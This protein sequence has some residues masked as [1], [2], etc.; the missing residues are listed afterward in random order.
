MRKQ[1]GFFFPGKISKQDIKA[2]FS[3]FISDWE[4]VSLFPNKKWEKNFEWGKSSFLEKVID[5]EKDLDFFL[6]HPDLYKNALTII[7]PWENVGTNPEKQTVRASKNIAYLSQKIADLDSILL[8]LWKDITYASKEKIARFVSGSFGYIVEGGAPSV[9]DQKTF[10]HP[11][12]S[13]EDLLSFIEE[14]LLNR[15]DRGAPGIFIC[16]GHQ[17]ACEAHIRLIRR[18]VKNILST[19]KLPHDSCNTALNSLQTLCKKIQ[20]VGKNIQVILQNGSCPAKSWDSSHFATTKNVVPELRGHDLVPYKIPLAKYLNVPVE[21]V[22]I[23]K[24]TAQNKGLIDLMEAYA[25]KIKIDMFHGDIAT[26]QAM[27]FASWAYTSIHYKLVSYR[28]LIAASP[29]RWLMNLPFAV[30][31]LASTHS[32]NQIVTANAATCIFYKDFDSGKF[33]RSFTTQ[34]HPEL[35][36]DLKDFGNRKPPSYQELKKN[37]GKRL[38]IHLLQTAIGDG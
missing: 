12:C 4:S 30:K 37:V 14:L 18:A 16:L 7:E 2:Y 21:V 26:E 13:R 6:T 36:D 22:E 25:G 19:E 27:I 23:Y 32:Q 11:K 24:I 34:F 1:N 8:P 29:L 33:K 5:S 31:I 10:T 28:P 9:F 38:F 17:L 35:M 20:Q 3:Y 15:L